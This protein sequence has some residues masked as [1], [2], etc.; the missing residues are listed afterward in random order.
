MF[1]CKPRLAAGPGPGLGPVLGPGPSPSEVVIH[2]D[3]YGSTVIIWCSLEGRHNCAIFCLLIDA[4][5]KQC[6]ET[7]KG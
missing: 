6:S 5:S 3:Y 4:G 2:L 7:N 1:M